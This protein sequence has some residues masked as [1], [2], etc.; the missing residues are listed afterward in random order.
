MDWNND[1][2]LDI[3]SGCYW[4]DNADAGHINLLIGEEGGE[5]AAAEPLLSASGEP[6]V[7]VPPK[8]EEPNEEGSEEE[9]SSPGDDIEWNNICTH[10]HAVDYDGDGDLDLVTG[11]IGNTFFFVENTG[12]DQDRVLT[13]TPLALQLTSPGAHSSPHLVDWDGDGDL[14]LLTG[15]SNGGAYL[16]E[17]SGTR[18]VPVWEDF[19][20]LIPASKA[21]SQAE[22]KGPLVPAPSTRIWVVDWN[23]DGLLD[24]LLGDSVTLS[25]RKEGLTDSEYV[26]LEKAYNQR[27]KEAQASYSEMTQVYFEAES[28]GEVSDELQEEFQTAQANFSEVYQSKSE[29]VSETRTGHVWVYLQTK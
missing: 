15:S 1:G 21:S 8:S 14:D 26:E 12:S 22:R 10:Q 16:S 2:T 19:K 6:L 11:N 17:N 24:I 20:T 25:D 13:D 28:K 7:N 5:Y 18:S 4:S 23:Q 27:L 29:F 9:P 3:L